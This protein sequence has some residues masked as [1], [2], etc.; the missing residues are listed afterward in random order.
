MAQLEIEAKRE[1]LQR[2]DRLEREEEE[3]LRAKEAE[4]NLFKDQFRSFLDSD[5]KATVEARNAAHKKTQERMAVTHKT[6]TIAAQNAGLRNAIAHHEEKLE[7]WSVYKE[8]LEGLTPPDWREEHPEPEMYFKEPEQL[9]VLMQ[10]LESQNMFLVGHCQDA[11]ALLEWYRA[12]FTESI[13]KNDEVLGNMSARRDARKVELDEE[14]AAAERYKVVGE[15]R[16]GN[17]LGEEEMTELLAA[18]RAFH[19]KLGYDSGS[20]VATVTMLTRIENAMQRLTESL[21]KMDRKLLKERAR[22]KL[23]ERMDLER[24]EKNARDKKEQ[25][26][27]A[28]RAIQHAMM[29]IKRRSGRPPIGRM[30][31]IHVESRDKLDDVIVRRRARAAANI[32]LLYGELWD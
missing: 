12:K 30:L 27:K 7:E 26:E 14:V 8:F 29:P 5:D 16:H 4:L 17:E 24:L 15:F 23:L 25:D 32:D 28:Q 3:S 9:I 31:P 21:G 20:S 1:E 22:A 10:W 18:V 2:I 19:V 13:R 11:E 6:K